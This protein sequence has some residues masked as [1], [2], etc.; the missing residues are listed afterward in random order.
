MRRA[1]PTLVAGALALVYVIVSPASLDLAAHLPR[2]RLFSAEGFGIWDNWWYAGHHTLGY[3]VLFPPLAAL[4]TPQIVAGIATTGAAALFEPL[5]RDHFG[6]E[7]WLGA[8]WFGAGTA[9][10]LFT[11]RLTFAFALLPMVG[12]ALAL[13][14]RRDALAVALAVVTAL[15]SPVAALFSALVGAAYALG[16]ERR[17]DRR[18]LTGAAVVAASLVP[19]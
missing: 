10:N 4:L 14:H 11:G 16:G 2:A 3:S 1:A 7:A 6:E 8:V 17:R 5:A 18:M 19:V 12:V 15:A 9:T 13:E